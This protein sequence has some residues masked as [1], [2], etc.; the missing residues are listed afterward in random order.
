MSGL[1]GNY[2]LTVLWNIFV[3]DLDNGECC[4]VFSVYCCGGI[5]NRG[6]C[7]RNEAEGNRS[8]QSCPSHHQGK[9]QEMMLCVP[10]SLY[11]NWNMT[12]TTVLC[13]TLVMFTVHS[14]LPVVWPAL[15]MFS[16]NQFT[17]LQAENNFFR[18][19]YGAT[20]FSKSQVWNE[21]VDI[22]ILD[23]HKADAAFLSLKQAHAKVWHTYDM[24]WRSKQ[25]GDSTILFSF[26]Y[27][28]SS[29]SKIICHHAV[30]VWCVQA[31]LVSR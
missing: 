1:E 31:W 3:F 26:W 12:N 7:T 23:Q 28:W 14:S 22:E 9:T 29:K 30:C 20:W 4:L 15:Q 24:Q 25:K 21:L 27:L 2:A 19:S 5:W 17:H 6:T 13:D 10:F 8:L 18:F 16:C 11:A